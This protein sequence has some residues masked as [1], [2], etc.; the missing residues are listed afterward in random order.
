MPNYKI[1]DPALDSA[2]NQISKL[3]EKHNEVVESGFPLTVRQ[4]ADAI[5]PPDAR[6]HL[7]KLRDMGVTSVRRSTTISAVIAHDDIAR[8]AAVNITVDPAVFYC[9][10]DQSRGVYNWALANPQKRPFDMD[11]LDAETRKQLIVW[12]NDAVRERRRT[13][14]TRR[15]V[16][17]FLTHHCDSTYVLRARWPALA[18]LFRGKWEGRLQEVPRNLNR[19]RWNRAG[20]EAEKWYAK[21]SKAIAI[22][23]Q[24]I[25]GSSMITAE[26]PETKVTAAIG[27]YFTRENEPL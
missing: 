5:A 26:T 11:S 19:W 18:P 23:E 3:C 20:F 24:L 10:E 7:T 21:N 1:T 27:A 13:A 6:E 2:K 25:V 8:A 9:F 17:H 15:V 22:A 16:N 4:V 14:L 12:V